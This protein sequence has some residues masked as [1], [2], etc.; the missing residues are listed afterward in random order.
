MKESFI[1]IED[2]VGWANANGVP[3][4]QGLLADNWHPIDKSAIGGIEIRNNIGP[5]LSFN[6]G[7]EP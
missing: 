2:E 3:N 7:V 6:L 5:L 4:P 1:H